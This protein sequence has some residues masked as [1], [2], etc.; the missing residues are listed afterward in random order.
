MGE[1]VIR[2]GLR[3]LVGR[4]QADDAMPGSFVGFADRRHREALAGAGLAVDQ[5]QAFGAGRMQER[6]DLLGGDAC[7]ICSG[8]SIEAQQLVDLVAVAVPP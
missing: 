1:T 4:G 2:H 6:P 8:I 7:G 3:D 5:R